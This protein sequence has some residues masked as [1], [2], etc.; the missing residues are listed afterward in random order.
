MKECSIDGCDDPHSA[1]G[2]CALH[3]QQWWAYGDPEYSPR[4]IRAPI[5][6]VPG[7]EGKHHARN[8]CEPHYRRW[9][10]HGT[11]WNCWTVLEINENKRE[12]STLMWKKRRER[13]ALQEV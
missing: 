7:C 2:W 9:L 8:W 10:K 4:I 5:C 6:T 1:R 12:A 11:V 3:Y 13:L